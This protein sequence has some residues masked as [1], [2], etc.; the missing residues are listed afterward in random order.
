MLV[1]VQDGTFHKI[2]MRGLLGNF[3]QNF[4]EFFGT[5]PSNPLS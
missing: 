1:M 3:P 4:I 5:L 2:N